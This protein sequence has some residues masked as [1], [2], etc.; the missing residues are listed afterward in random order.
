MV[1]LHLS[2]AGLRERARRALVE[3]FDAKTN[4]C[5]IDGAC[6]LKLAL[7]QAQRAFFAELEKYTLASFVARAPALI[8]LWKRQ[9]KE[10]PA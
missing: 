2:R 3:C 8:T 9:M 1:H 4:T 7:V 6:G 5:P 10:H